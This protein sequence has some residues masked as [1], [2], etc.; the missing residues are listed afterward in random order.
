MARLIFTHKLFF[1]TTHGVQR[2]ADSAVTAGGVILKP[3]DEQTVNLKQPQQ[4]TGVAVR[5]DPDGNLHITLLP[6]PK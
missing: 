4:V 5:R 3:G 6:E 1:E 2:P